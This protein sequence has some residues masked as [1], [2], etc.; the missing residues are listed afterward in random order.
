MALG[1]DYSTN[2]KQYNE[3]EVYSPYRMSNVEGVD[4]SALSVGFF[5][6][7]L[8][9]TISPMLPK[10]TETKKWD[11][12]NSMTVYLTHVK[13]RM[14]AKI[15]EDVMDPNKPNIENG[16]VNTGAEGFVS[17]SNGKELGTNNYCLI[18]RKIDCNTG[19]VTTT[20][21][22]EF[23]MDY[24]YAIINFDASTS[25][26]DKVYFD[27]LEIEQFVDL[28]KEYYI[29][30]TN[31]TAYTVRNQMRFDMSKINTKLNGISEALGIT[32]DKEGNYSSKSSNKSFFNNSN[33]EHGKT[34]GGTGSSTTREATI[35][36][37]EGSM[38]PP[39]E[40]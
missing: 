2:K 9:L 21:V 8:K 35:D 24:H 27:N 16:G 15:I 39:E 19:E 3:P 5:R 38:N 30:S 10:P 34:H 7:C 20:Y 14:L 1:G 11:L 32:F 25:A 4:P 18:F 31:A 17:F 29:S 6:E 26:H 23:K 22:Y 28:L 33:S 36:Q 12:E 40:E 37:L 13:A